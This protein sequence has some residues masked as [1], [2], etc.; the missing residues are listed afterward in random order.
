MLVSAKP[1]LTPRLP[2]A[3]RLHFALSCKALL[4][5]YR[6]DEAAWLRGLQVSLAAASEP[7]VEACE[8]R[9]QRLLQRLAPSSISS[10]ALHQQTRQADSQRV[11]SLLGPLSQGLHTLTIHLEHAFYP[12]FEVQL[13]LPQL[14]CSRIIGSWQA[15]STIR[16]QTPSLTY[17]DLGCSTLAGELPLSLTHLSLCD[18]DI[19]EATGPSIFAG[20]HSVCSE[21]C[22]QMVGIG[23]PAAYRSE[24]ASCPVCSYQAALAAAFAC[25]LPGSP[26]WPEPA[27]GFEWADCAQLCIRQPCASE[28]RRKAGNPAMCGD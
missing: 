14:R 19:R 12:V 23:F 10:L 1:V 21:T 26:R 24:P 6:Q 27:D 13:D 3:C 5:Q 22:W 4:R 17:L 9:L 28:H 18:V 2:S 8:E 15:V 16:L 20:A 25:P 7:D 11:L